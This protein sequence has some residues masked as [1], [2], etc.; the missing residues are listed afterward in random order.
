M[1]IGDALRTE[2]NR[3]YWETD[4][5]VGEI[6]DRLG[7]SRRALYEALDPAPAGEACR[8]CG[9]ILIFH[10][11]LARSAGEA[12]CPECGL[13]QSIA[14][15]REQTADAGSELREGADAVERA[16]GV[17]SEP[18]GLVPPTSADRAGPTVLPF[19]RAMRPPRKRA[20]ALGGTVLAGALA[21]ALTTLLL[22]RG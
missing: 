22:K 18:E 14:A 2:A 12:Q 17:V 16:A 21:G 10:N 15:L 5:S 1:T 13:E 6:T 20:I 8:D 4:T 7:V 3:L 9:A 11:R 19:A